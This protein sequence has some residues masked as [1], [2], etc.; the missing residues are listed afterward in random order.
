MG[1]PKHPDRIL[2]IQDMTPANLSITQDESIIHHWVDP[3]KLKKLNGIWYKDRQRVVTK[4]SRE[5]QMIAEAHHDP[6][7]YGHLG[8]NKTIKLVE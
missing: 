5:K 4:G 6:P 2:T 8:I 3:H 7:V 1:M